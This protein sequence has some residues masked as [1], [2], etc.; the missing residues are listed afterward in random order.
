MTLG[1]FGS[2]RTPEK[3][4]G[5]GSGSLRPGSK[6]NAELAEAIAAAN[7]A[8]DGP[9]LSAVEDEL[10]EVEKRTPQLDIEALTVVRPIGMGGQG[11]VWLSVDPASGL[12]CAVKQIRKGRLS[13]LPKKAATRALLEREALLDVG[14]HPFITTLYATFQNESSLF[15][16]I[17]LAPGG[18]LFGLLDF[19]PTG[20]PEAQ[21]RFYVMCVAL[22]LR[23]VHA[24]GYVYRDV[25]LEN[26]LIGA[27]GYVKICDFG[28]AKKSADSRTFTKCGTDE[29]APPEVVSGRGRSCA[30]DWWALGILLHEMLTGRPPFE[31]TSAED[32]FKAISDFSRGGVMAAEQLQQ[33]L[34]RATEQT[35]E[36]GAAFLLGLLKARESERIGAGAAGF[37]QVQTHPWFTDVDWEAVL[38][39]RVKAPYVPEKTADGAV[40][41]ALE[42]KHEDVMKD[43]P[44]DSATWEPIFEVFGPKRTAPWADN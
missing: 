15:F 16:A 22:A 3:A 14:F 35:S 21:A 44:Y 20:L 18:D 33:A 29:Y 32:V 17:E 41:V 39:K 13:L 4:T 26:V 28:F 5:S 34:L 1:M 12:R 25:K 27:D 10:C 23:H 9:D 40:E 19:H 24:H 38:R 30:A 43:R 37:M 36:E 42:F 11:G 31:G 6:C 2:R 8:N 7:I